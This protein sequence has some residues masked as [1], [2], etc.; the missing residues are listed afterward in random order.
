M[1]WGTLQKGG[2]VW[3]PAV[4]GGGLRGGYVQQPFFHADVSSVPSM[5][6]VTSV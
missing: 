5:G 6:T 2:N 4:E 1:A 3:G